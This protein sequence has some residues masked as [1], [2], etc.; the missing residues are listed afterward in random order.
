ML[1][2]IKGIL[3]VLNIFNSLCL[4]GDVIDLPFTKIVPDLSNQSPEDILRKRLHENRIIT[5]IKVGTE[6]QKIPMRIDLFYYDFYISGKTK[7]NEKSTNIIFDQSNSKTFYQKEKFAEFGGRGFNIGYKASDIFLNSDDNQN[8]NLSFILAMDSD[9]GNSGMIGLKISSQE[10]EEI[11]EY[12]FIKQLKKANAIKN[13][14][15]TIKYTDDT[16][17]NLIIGD[18][19]ENYDNKFRGIEY[20]DTYV[21]N[22][23]DPS[24][25]NMK[26]DSIYT[27][28][29]SN[30]DKTDLG[31]TS[32]FF[33]INLIMTIGTKEYLE[34]LKKS[35]MDEQINNGICF[36]L[37]SSY[38][39][40]YYCKK[41]VNFS[42]MKN[43]Y[44]YNKELDYNFEFTYKDLFFYNELDTNYYFLIKFETSQNNRWLIGEFFFK[45]YQLIFNQEI[46][47]IGIYTGKLDNT[48][49]E[50]QSWLSSNKWYL[51]LI[52]FLVILLI[53]ISV[54]A[55][56]YIKSI[57]KR[58]KKANELDDDDYEYT[59]N[60]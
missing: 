12:N 1:E 40:T 32:I 52:V 49:T 30:K 16:H 41:N 26:I 35:F 50:N 17:G 53:V 48:K 54:L 27:K 42:K 31:N 11:I 4:Q 51:I 19:P 7:E 18:L 33:R 59:I 38:Y 2:L 28:L 44:F 21:I 47:K 23:E 39:Y 60:K 22:P 13:Y 25:W 20:K 58:K 55:Y 3:I 15:F 46:K 9:E 14:Y 45:K 10:D 29:A 56:L 36:E 57:P 24:S 6:P 8:Y 34:E 5:E 43:L 37:K